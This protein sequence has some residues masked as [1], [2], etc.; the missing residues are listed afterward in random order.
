MSSPR[1]SGSCGGEGEG[2]KVRVC[3][4]G[5]CQVGKT[6]LVSQFVTSEHIHT[7]DSSLGEFWRGKGKYFHLCWS[8]EEYGEKSI[9]VKIDSEEVE[10][11]FIDHPSNEMSV[12]DSRN[13]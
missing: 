10:L 4:M 2:R 7:F 3:M 5:D 1:L 12:G 8:D 6:S 9:S 11:C 13:P